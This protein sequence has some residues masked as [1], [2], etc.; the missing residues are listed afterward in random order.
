MKLTA[1]HTML[2]GYFNLDNGSG[3]IRSVYL[4]G[5]DTMRPIFAEWLAP[6]CEFG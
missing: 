3:K 4:Q 5:N 1:V 2:S 6:F